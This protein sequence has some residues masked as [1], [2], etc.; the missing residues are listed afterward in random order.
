MIV[1]RVLKKYNKK[2]RVIDT[3]HVAADPNYQYDLAK[4]EDEGYSVFL[5][6]GADNL[7]TPQQQKFLYTLVEKATHF[8]WL[9]F[10]SITKQDF[11]QKLQKQAT[12]RIPKVQVSFHMERNYEDYC[13]AMTQ[14]LI[15]VGTKLEEIEPYKTFTKNLNLNKWLNRVPGEK[16][17]VVMKQLAYQILTYIG[18]KNAQDWDIDEINKTITKILECFFPK[19]SPMVL[20]LKDQSLRSQCVFLCVWRLLLNK[21]ADEE[22]LATPRTS[23]RNVFLEFKKLVNNYYKVL[24]VSSDSFVFRALDHLVKMGLLAADETNTSF[25]KVWLR[26]DDTIVKDTISQLQLP[27]RVDDFFATILK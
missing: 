13:S 25:R 26:I 7:I 6:R 11:A 5:V 15:P 16:P 19:H 17:F 9:V 22:A 21:E 1:Q 23:Y 2:L 20:L 8:T 10:F 3:G 14:F 18:R 12:S 27:S 24:D 4:E